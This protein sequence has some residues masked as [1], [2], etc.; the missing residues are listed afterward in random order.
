MPF[1]VRKP[2]LNLSIAAACALSISGCASN[3]THD[4][5]DERQAYENQKYYHPNCTH[6]PE[7]S[8]THKQCWADENYKERKQRESNREQL[9]RQ[10]QDIDDSLQPLN[11]KKLGL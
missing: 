3:G 5:S 11:N 9:R 8:A 6:L 7:G 1:L 2:L 4:T 10:T